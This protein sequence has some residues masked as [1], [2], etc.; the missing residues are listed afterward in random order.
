MKFDI[1]IHENVFIF[2]Y[3]QIPFISTSKLNLSILEPVIQG[4][5]DI[6]HNIGRVQVLR[7]QKM[8]MN[9]SQL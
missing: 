4:Y 2:S 3:A 7:K 8:L 1:R 5:I 6:Q 9:H